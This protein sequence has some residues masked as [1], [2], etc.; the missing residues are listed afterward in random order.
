[1]AKELLSRRDFL[2]FLGLNLALVSL[3]LSSCSRLFEDNFDFQAINASREDQLILA[4]GFSYDILRSWKD[5][6]NS[7]ELFGT[8]NDYLAFFELN[9][10][11]A[12]L[13]VNHEG[14]DTQYIKDHQEQ[15]KS[16]GG[17]VIAI[18]KQK[19]KWQ[20]SHNPE[21]QE[22]YN[23]RYD[24]N[25]PV[26][27][28][29]PASQI[30]GDYFGTL[31]NCSGG[32][33]PWNTVLSCE[34]NYNHF[35]KY[36]KWKNFKDEY[37]GWVVEIDPF[38]KNCLPV[39]H[40]ALGRF[41][42]ENAATVLAKDKRLVV[43]M[44]DD[45]NDEHIY[46]YVSKNS[47]Q[48]GQENP[49]KLL[50]EGDLYVAQLDSA[51]K[52]GKWKILNLSDP[53]LAKKFSSQGELLIETRKAAKIIG[54]TKMNRPED[55]EVSPYDN[56]IFIAQTHNP[57]QNDKHGSI[58]KIVED[59]NDFTSPEF[60]YSYFLE[61]GEEAGLTSPD[62][63]AFDNRGNL[64]V[65][66]DVYGP[67]LWQADYKFA[68]NNSLFCIPLRGKEAGKVKRFASAPNGAEITGPC[69]SK[70]FK[71]LFLSIQ[72]PGEFPS[73]STWPTNSEPRSCVVAINL[74]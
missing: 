33:T 74:V 12:L 35:T 49:S 36:Y 22:K 52:R 34:E 4:P 61:G 9:K 50:E 15:R 39:K 11:Q 21:L 17:S 13:W 18:E 5:P 16:V 67:D 68:G 29:G 45:T 71:T 57:N 43:Y 20:F 59:Q 7:S 24:A 40:T 8:N 73:K 1:V 37:Y 28:S 70:D 27:Y 38:N 2:K 53:K 25:T 63:L 65:C 64:W 72:H 31:A 48:E 47:Y 10:N 46:K 62:N 58:L 55:I 23:C 6:I 66:S 26:T 42:H 69:F 19:Q 30:L 3:D 56:S 14:I 32:I 54:A 41:M 60:S 44:G 51:N